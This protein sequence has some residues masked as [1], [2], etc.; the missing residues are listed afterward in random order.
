MNE[1]I[2]KGNAEHLAYGR[3]NYEK[4]RE[5]LESKGYT[6]SIDYED[7]GINLDM[8]RDEM[9]NLHPLSMIILSDEL[10]KY[11]NHLQDSIVMTDDCRWDE[12]TRE[13]LIWEYDVESLNDLVVF[14]YSV[15][16]SGRDDN[17]FKFTYE[18]DEKDLEDTL[19]D[20]T[21]NTGLL[22]VAKKKDILKGEGLK[23][24]SKKT[25]DKYK[26]IVDGYTKTMS[27]CI[28]NEIFSAI[29]E[30]NEGNTLFSCG[31]Y[32]CMDFLLEDVMNELPD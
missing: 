11:K 5:E 27:T 17:N 26:K 23:R 9:E 19:G 24:L 32:D 1:Y 8:L 2:I 31:G 25:R 12:E 7:Y 10:A 20:E 14:R 29:V 30:D 16:T 22:F 28:N 18:G 13:C 21:S 6:L 3:K 15:A 4:V